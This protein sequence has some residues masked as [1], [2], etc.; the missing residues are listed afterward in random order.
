VTS[1]LRLGARTQAQ[2]ADETG[3]SL[4][5]VSRAL[6]FLRAL[7]LVGSGRGRNATHTLLARDELFA[8]LK[9]ADRLAEQVNELREVAQ[10]EAARQTVRDQ[11]HGGVPA[12]ND[13]AADHR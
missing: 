1:E 10:R 12:P 11:L 7:G 13:Q 9:A 4:P 3:L 2:I 8:V 6:G 5:V